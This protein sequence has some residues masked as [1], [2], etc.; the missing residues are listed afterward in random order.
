MLA[1]VLGP[2][3]Y[4]IYLLGNSLYNA[5]RADTPEEAKIKAEEEQSNKAKVGLISQ[6]IICITIHPIYFF[7]MRLKIGFF[8][9][10]KCKIYQM[11][12][13]SA[14]IPQTT[15]RGNTNNG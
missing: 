5:L 6:L 10:L 1:D 13:R 3:F 9:L 15:I 4:G 8:R 12:P 14:A 11:R 2:G 7:I